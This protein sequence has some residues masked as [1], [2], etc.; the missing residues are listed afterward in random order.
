MYAINELKKKQI[1][2]L[3]IA[4][5][6]LTRLTIFFACRSCEY[7]K[8]PAVE[9]QQRTTILQLRNIRFFR[10]GTIVNHNNAELEYSDCVLLTFKKQKKDK[11]MD[12]ITHM[13]QVK[14]NFILFA[15]QQVSFAV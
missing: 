12:T 7:L 9:Q 11:K 1:S 2:E 13:L 3:C 5:F 4:M 8:V 15:Q 14:Q 10:D 6:Q